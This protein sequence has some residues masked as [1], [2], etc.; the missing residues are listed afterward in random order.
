[1]NL[2]QISAGWARQVVPE[3]HG[4]VPAARRIVPWWSRDYSTHS[5]AGRVS[6]RSPVPRRRLTC[7]RID[8]KLLPGQ[9]SYLT[10]SRARHL[11]RSSEGPLGITIRKG[12]ADRRENQGSGPIHRPPVSYAGKVVVVREAKRVTQDLAETGNNT[13]EWVVWI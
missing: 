10:C 11:P 5:Q 9:I 6:T 12:P 2:L 13:K 8:N 4:V 1:M 7:G 3:A